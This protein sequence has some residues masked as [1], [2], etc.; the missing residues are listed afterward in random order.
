MGCPFGQCKT[1]RVCIKHCLFEPVDTRGMTVYGKNNS[2]QCNISTWPVG[3]VTL[4]T[5]FGSVGIILNIMLLYAHKKDPCKVLRTSSS[6]FIVNIA[7]I[8]L[9]AS[10]LYLFLALV[11][12][13]YFDFDVTRL[14]RTAVSLLGANFF[15]F[16]ETISFTSF[17]SLSIERF[18]SIAF[19]LWHRVRITTRVCRYWLGTV[20]LFH[21]IFETIEKT[22]SSFLVSI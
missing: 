6:I 3:A 14:I 15:T 16:L 17:L 19:P 2:T 7:F 18:C 10:C 9:L 12:I 22:I 21:F 20:W 4:Q 8:D 1:S 11:V 5:L 13:F